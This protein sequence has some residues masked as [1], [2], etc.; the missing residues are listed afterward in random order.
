M[1]ITCNKCGE[2][3]STDVPDDTVIR[4]WVECPECKEEDNDNRNIETDMGTAVV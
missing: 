3:V 1:L 4:A 2:P